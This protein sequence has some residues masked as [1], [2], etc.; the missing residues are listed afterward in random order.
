MHRSSRLVDSSF[1]PETHPHID[2]TIM[3]QHL[4]S[5]VQFYHKIKTE[6]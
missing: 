2:D 3:I 4:E 6:R 1:P 5:P